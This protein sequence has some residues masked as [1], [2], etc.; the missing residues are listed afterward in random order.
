MKKSKE[1]LLSEYPGKYLCV[2]NQEIAERTFS[3]LDSERREMVGLLILMVQG[4]RQ[5]ES[6]KPIK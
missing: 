5:V 1:F 6:I 2:Q 3:G 4:S